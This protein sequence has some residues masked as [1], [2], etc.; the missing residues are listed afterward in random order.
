M[1]RRLPPLNALRAFEA[2][3]R[4]LSFA[5]AAAELHVTPAAISHQVKSL[6]AY[7]GI[8][9]FRRLPRGLLLTDAGQG[10]LPLLGKGFDEFAAAI[11]S[12]RRSGNDRVLTVTIMP[13][14]AAKWLLRASPDFQR[15]H[16]KIDL[17]ISATTRSVDLARDNVD[18]GIRY[19]LGDWPGLRI[20]L[21][22]TEELFPVC[23]PRLLEG[24]HGLRTPDDLRHHTLLHDLSSW[25]PELAGE[26]PDWGTWFEAAGIEDIDPKRGPALTPS[27]MVIDAAVAGQGVALGRSV[28]V[29]AD[30]ADGRLVKPFGPTIPSDYAYYLI[31]PDTK[32]DLPKV[33]AFREWATDAFAKRGK[34]DQTTTA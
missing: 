2:A 25:R 7:L 8:Q 22:S 5:K 20:D 29:E 19:G 12:V 18:V 13:S 9:L 31:C 30:L 24:P 6:E 4:H 3:G 16:P 21:L 34:P 26:V 23:S 1:A 10:C 17:H 28:L 11:D 32:A 33:V 15:L 14:L 27:D